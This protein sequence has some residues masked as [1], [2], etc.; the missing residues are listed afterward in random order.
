LSN[1]QRS[2]DELLSHFFQNETEYDKY[3]EVATKG[4]EAFI[5]SEEI[6]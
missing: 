5:S 1:I 6:K 4:R 3:F 2:V